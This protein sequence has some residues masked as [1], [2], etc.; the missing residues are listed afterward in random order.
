MCFVEK[1]YRKVVHNFIILLVL[2]IDSHKS[3]RLEAMLFTCSVTESVQF[4]Y[5][6][7]RLHC[8]L[9]FS[10]ESVLINY[11]REGYCFQDR[12]SRGLLLPQERTRRSSVARLRHVTRFSPLVI[13]AAL[14]ILVT[15]SETLIM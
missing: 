5:R 7:Q 2:K 13:S 12:W 9:K 4:Q 3:D 10:L 15:V 14:K 8:L 1:S 6:F 11:G